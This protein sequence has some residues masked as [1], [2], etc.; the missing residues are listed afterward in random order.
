[1]AL[2]HREGTGVEVAISIDRHPD[3]LVFQTR[4]DG[5]QS[6]CRARCMSVYGGRDRRPL[7]ATSDIATAAELP[8]LR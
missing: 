4:R 5:D 2:E 3:L 7:R 6:E 1:M 8:I